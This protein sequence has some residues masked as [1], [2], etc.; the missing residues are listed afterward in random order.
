MKKCLVHI[1]VYDRYEGVIIDDVIYFESTKS[2]L[3]L[4]DEDKEL[5]TTSY[6]VVSIEND[7]AELANMKDMEMDW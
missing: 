5:G 1:A 7:K 4:I 2:E 6:E 3:V